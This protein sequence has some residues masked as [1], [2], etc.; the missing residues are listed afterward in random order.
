[1]AKKKCTRSTR[2]VMKTLTL[3][4]MLT[5]FDKTKK[6]IKKLDGKIYKE[7][8]HIFGIRVVRASFLGDDE[9]M[10]L[11]GKK[12]YKKIAEYGKQKK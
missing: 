3:Q 12:A 4:E 5:A 2:Q 10:I 11:A 9:W 6:F 7:I 8:G 1:M